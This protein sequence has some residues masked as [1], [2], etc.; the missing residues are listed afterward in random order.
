MTIQTEEIG[1][2][3]TIL[4]TAKCLFIEHGYNGLSMRAIS[5]KIGVSKAALYYH[6]NDKE[7][8]FVAV[9]NRSLEEIGRIIDSIF[10]KPIFNS[11]KIGQFIEYI[12]NQPAEQGAMI[13]LGSQEM[14]H[15]SD[16]SR[17]QFNETYHNGF[18][19]KLNQIIRAGVENGEFR[20][21]DPDIATW[22]LLGLMYPYLYPNLAGFSPLSTEKI[23]MIVNIFMNGIQSK[24]RNEIIVNR[25][26]EVQRDI[27]TTR[28]DLRG[29]GV[30][31]EDNE[32]GVEN[33]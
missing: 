5:E 33:Q 17:Q 9:L 6:F 27:V 1:L 13:R 20:A 30:D 32:Q 19:G 29:S 21:V 14:T 22:A 2:R 15:L 31:G 7:E 28:A 26:P 4:D 18:T 11:E 8:L 25:F 10:E 16:A 12:L 24:N 3:V 23:Q